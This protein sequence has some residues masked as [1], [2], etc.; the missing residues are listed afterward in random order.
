M[1]NLRCL[2]YLIRLIQFEHQPI[3]IAVEVQPAPY[4]TE[5]IQE[6]VFFLMMCT[7]TIKDLIR[8]DLVFVTIWLEELQRIRLEVERLIQG[9]LFN[10][11]SGTRNDFDPTIIEQKQAIQHLINAMQHINQA[12]E[13]RSKQLINELNRLLAVEPSAD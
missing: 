11:Q 2:I 13:F 6:W 5:L 9:Q 8:R 1:H 12:L 10:Y 7:V 3:T 4:P